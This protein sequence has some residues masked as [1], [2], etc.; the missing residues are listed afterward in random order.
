TKTAIVTGASRGIGRAIATRLAAAGFAVVV[1]Y[2]GGS[3]AAQG[4]VDGLRHAGGEAMVQQADIS[5]PEQV[6]QMFEKTIEAYGHIDVV[7]NNAG[8][9]ENSLISRGDVASFDR[10]I[11]TNLRG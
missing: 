2:A 10:V 3:K 9:M 5:N 1:N 8:I 6:K 11:A 4:G 7:V